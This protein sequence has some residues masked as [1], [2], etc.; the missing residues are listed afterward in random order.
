[1]IKK[2]RRKI[3]DVEAVRWTGDNYSEIE[4]FTEGASYLLRR[5]L[6]IKTTNSEIIPNTGDYII[7]S[8]DQFIT[9]PYDDF[10]KLYEEVK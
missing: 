3:T 2:Y 5:C 8:N 6:F 7:K 9:C 1:M 10:E 4:E